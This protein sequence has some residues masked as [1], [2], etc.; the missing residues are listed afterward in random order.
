MSILAICLFIPFMIKRVAAELNFMTMI[1][2]VQL[3]IDSYFEVFNFNEARSSI[4]S[5]GEKASLKQ[6]IDLDLV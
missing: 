6:Y 3:N 1:D 2:N 5:D 4:S